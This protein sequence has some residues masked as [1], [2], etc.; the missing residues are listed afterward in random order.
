MKKPQK[1]KVKYQT[2]RKKSNKLLIKNKLMKT[3]V[4]ANNGDYNVII[5]R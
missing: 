5:Q 4:D 2:F 1:S 3:T